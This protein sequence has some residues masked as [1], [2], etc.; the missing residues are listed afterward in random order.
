[1]YCNPHSTNCKFPPGHRIRIKQ[2]IA[3]TKS[4]L[5]SRKRKQGTAI[6]ARSV[7][8]KKKQLL[9]KHQQ[10]EV[11]NEAGNPSK[12]Q[13][14][15]AITTQVR[16]TILKYLKGHQKELGKLKDIQ[17]TKSF[18]IFVTR[19]ASRDNGIFSAKIVN[20]VV[21]ALLCTNNGSLIARKPIQ[22]KI[23]NVTHIR[24]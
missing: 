20:P 15:Y 17:E 6:P 14:V 12:E 18:S 8:T 21:T 10:L 16:A 1:M 22:L 9:S 13:N 24:M 11:S 7:D 19:L 4:L 3:E 5:E 23:G 2:F